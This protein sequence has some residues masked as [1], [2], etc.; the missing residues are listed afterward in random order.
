[1]AAR[2]A[3]SLPDRNRLENQGEGPSDPRLQEQRAEEG[4]SGSDARP[5]RNDVH[6]VKGRVGPQVVPE[7]INSERSGVSCVEGVG[8]WDGVSRQ[9]RTPHAGSSQGRMR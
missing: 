1:M 8:P 4:R 3:E 2:V 6:A 7:V 5:L 9:D